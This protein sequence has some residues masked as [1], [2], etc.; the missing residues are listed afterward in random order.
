MVFALANFWGLAAI[1]IPIVIPLATAMN[2]DLYLVSAAVFSGAAFGSHA[3]FY[4]DAAILIG[5]ATNIRPY[6]HAIT[7]LPY[8]IISAVITTILYLVFGFMK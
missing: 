2:V 5:Q 4:A 1:V 6:D 8:A 3:C 7:Q